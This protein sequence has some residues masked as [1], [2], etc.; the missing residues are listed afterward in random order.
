MC[1]CRSSPYGFV[2]MYVPRVQCMRFSL[3]MH[4][5]V[6]QFLNAARNDVE[7]GALSVC[8]VVQQLVNVSLFAPAMAT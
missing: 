1:V 4:A 3:R 7:F 8:I 5:R 6:E 2:S